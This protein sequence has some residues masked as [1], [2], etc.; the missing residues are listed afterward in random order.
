[1]HQAGPSNHHGHVEKEPK[2]KGLKEAKAV[3]V[4]HDLSLDLGG[5]V[6]GALLLADDR[7]VFLG[8]VAFILVLAGPLV[9][10]LLVSD[11]AAEDLGLDAHRGKEHHSEEGD[12]GQGDGHEEKE[13]KGVAF[14]PVGEEEGVEGGE[15]EGR[16]AKEGHEE[17]DDLAPVLRGEILD[18]GGHGGHVHPRGAD[19]G[20]EEIEGEKQVVGV[21]KVALKGKG[22]AE[23]ANKD[24]DGGH[25]G[26][27]GRAVRVAEPA[28]EGLGDVE[29]VVADPD[30]HGDLGGGVGQLALQLL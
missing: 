26:G 18:I 11:G 23:V 5:A 30:D 7:G 24:A 12:G 1:V 29:A 4:H 25:E 15:D 9:F 21:D 6:D 27:D 20:Q 14:G 10:L 22:H 17:A 28:D 13:L 8:R 3:D 16:E 2:V 19:A